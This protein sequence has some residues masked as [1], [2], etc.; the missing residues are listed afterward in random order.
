[1][2]IQ[3]ILGSLE[4]AADVSTRG[5]FHA[6]RAA[7]V[8]ATDPATATEHWTVTGVGYEQMVPITLVK[9]AAGG[10]QILMPLEPRDRNSAP[11]EVKP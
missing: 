7:I 2:L 8:V 3:D 9:S 1:V 10:T 6:V 4:V 5:M 11:S